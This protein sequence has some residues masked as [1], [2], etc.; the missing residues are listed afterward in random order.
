M[1]SFAFNFLWV[2]YH[3]IQVDF[4]ILNLLLY[5]DLK[6]LPLCYLELNVIATPGGE[7]DGVVL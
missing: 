5:F 4:F 7:R 2:N 3:E 1:G 6:S